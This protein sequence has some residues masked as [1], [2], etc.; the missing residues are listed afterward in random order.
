MNVDNF[1]LH[2]IL[3]LVDLNCMLLTSSSFGPFQ[4]NSLPEIGS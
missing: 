3:S 4:G 2:S 1:W